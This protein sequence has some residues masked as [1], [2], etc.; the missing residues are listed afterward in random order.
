MAGEAHDLAARLTDAGFSVRV[1][2]DDPPAPPEPLP[3]RLADEV[4]SCIALGHADAFKLD[5]AAARDRFAGCETRMAPA[6]SRD[7]DGRALLSAL[8]AEEADALL[9]SG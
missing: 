4:K 5:Y 6:L 1:A 2:A 7:A 3:P 8:L 9:A